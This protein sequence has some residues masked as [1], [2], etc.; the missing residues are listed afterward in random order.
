MPVTLAEIKGSFTPEEQAQIDRSAQ[1]LVAN[2]RSLAELRRLLGITQA[3]VAQALKT[4]QGNVAQI[5]G[6]KDVM[7]STLARV[8]Q[9]LGGGL[10]LRVVLPGRRSVTLDMAQNAGAVKLKKPRRSKTV[11]S[12]G[13]RKAD[14]TASKRRASLGPAPRKVT[15]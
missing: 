14:D 9:A 3:E 10:E 6:K 4:T 7:V 2:N 5:E 15:R 13:A 12:S 8:V 1:E 11:V